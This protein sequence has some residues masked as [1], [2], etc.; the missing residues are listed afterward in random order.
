MTAEPLAIAAA[1]PPRPHWLTGPLAAF[2]RL[3]CGAGARWVEDPGSPAGRQVIFFANHSSHLDPVVIWAALPAAWRAVTRPVA[4][5]DY[6]QKG[7]LR[8]FLAL[9]V[10]RAVLIDR[11]AGAQAAG[12]RVARARGVV[13]Q[14]LAEMGDASSLILF[15]EG[16][17][18]AAEEPASFKSGLYYLA[19]A[20]PRI[21]LVPVYLE[22]LGRIL[23][24]G[25]FLPVPLL[26][27][28]TFGRSLHLEADEGRDAF[29]QRMRAAVVGLRQGQLAR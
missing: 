28:A 6:W 17:R 1:A 10:F 15:P 21:A 22:N 8:R 12:D 16:T 18:G 23:P 13:E 29:L 19:K 25:E 5:R 26:A 7:A 24:K 9:R 27:T 4:A 20:Q 3:L 14:T 2:V 11:A